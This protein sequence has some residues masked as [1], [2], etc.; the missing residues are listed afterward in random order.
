MKKVF[1]I[2]SISSI[3][4]VIL[5][6]FINL[7]FIIN[8]YGKDY[9]Y[10]YYSPNHNF[11]W[12]LI[13]YIFPISVSLLLGFVFKDFNYFLKIGK[14]FL[15]VLLILSISGAIINKNYWGYYI[16]RP[17]TFSELSNANEVLSITYL[18][19]NKTNYYKV[20]D[21][22]LFKSNNHDNEY[23]YY[24]FEE[25]PIIAML[26]NSQRGNLYDWKEIYNSEKTKL[27]PIEIKKIESIIKSSKFIDVA[28]KKYESTSRTNALAI[29]FVTSKENGPTYMSQN[30]SRIPIDKFEKKYIYLIISFG[31]ISN[32]HFGIYEFL[33]ENNKIIKKQKYY[34]D[35]AGIEGMEYQTAAPILEFLLL[36]LVILLSILTFYF[37]KI[38]VNKI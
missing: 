14:I 19:K 18:E 15:P 23:Y 4:F 7:I 13:F 38:I 2:L 32:D 21:S 35:V 12:L 28:E 3:F 20:N 24:L 30:F 16:K 1:S 6:F 8:E 37:K 11:L 34:Y 22:S 26:E 5:R 27:K 36:I 10:T 33:I 31:Q 25:R 29:E 17:T 9:C